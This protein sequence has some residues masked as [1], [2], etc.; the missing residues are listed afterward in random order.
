MIKVLSLALLLCLVQ[1]YPPMGRG[2][3]QGKGTALPPVQK[4]SYAELKAIMRR[5]SGN[6]ILVNAWA[7]WCK[8]CREEMPALVRLKQN[9]RKKNFTLIILSADETDILESDVRPMLKQLGVGFQSYIMNDKPETFMSAMNPESNAAFALPTTYV[10]N[11]QG[12]LVDMMVGDKTYKVFRDAVTK[13][14]RN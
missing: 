9:L 5:D 11:T 13:L 1:V 8:P 6:V 14:M 4:V 10:H 7:T 12:K 3:G 2:Q